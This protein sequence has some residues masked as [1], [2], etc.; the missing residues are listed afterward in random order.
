M[1]K[2]STSTDKYGFIVR[3]VQEQDYPDILKISKDIW[4]GYDYLPKV[5]H[6]WL[7]QPGLFIGVQDPIT[8]ELIAVSR[9]AL[10][11]DGTAWLGG[12]RVRPDY[13]GRG[14]SHLMI[15]AQ[16]NYAL[17]KL[18]QGS[19]QRIACATFIKNEAS[20]HLC[21]SYGMQIKQTFL[22]LSWSKACMLRPLQVEPWHPSWEEIEALPYFKDT[23]QVIVQFFKMQ[24]ISQAWWEQ[25]KK[26]FQLFKINGARGWIDQSQ[27]PHCVVLEPTA[28]SLHDWLQFANEK[29]SE[30]A[31]TVILPKARLIDE[32]KQTQLEA[33]SNWE[34]DCFYFV[35]ESPTPSSSICRTGT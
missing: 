20:K 8:N 2:I 33:W 3:P 10:L 30:E 25:S 14:I 12:L 27:E 9:V 26:D 6:A 31:S 29:L 24:Q 21:L 15:Q 5:F 11:H 23:K 34:P 16:I 18:L 4:E 17:E 35:Y 13:Q 32:L 28:T 22:L 1:N 19:V 7:R